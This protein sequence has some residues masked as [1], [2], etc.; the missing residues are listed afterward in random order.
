MG[1]L[2]ELINS[3]PKYKEAMKVA[4]KDIKNNFIGT[5]KKKDAKENRSNN[6][7]HFNRNW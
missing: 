1:I 4:I 6:K 7:K 5:K 3:D 2:Y